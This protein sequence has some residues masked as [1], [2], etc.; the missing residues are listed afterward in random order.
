MTELSET[1]LFD[2]L[3][4]QKSSHLFEKWQQSYLKN[5]KQIELIISVLI[6]KFDYI[7]KDQVMQDYLREKLTRLKEPE[8]YTY[9]NRKNEIIIRENFSLQFYKHKKLH[10]LNAPAVYHH[11]GSTE[12]FHYGTKQ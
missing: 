11:D 10:R 1:S 7:R 2:F 9:N 6:S 12:F 8:I 4:E 3:N 5:Q